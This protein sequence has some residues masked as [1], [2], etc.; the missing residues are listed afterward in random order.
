MTL[1]RQATGSLLA[2][3]FGSAYR[4]GEIASSCSYALNVA[5]PESQGNEAPRDER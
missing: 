2:T 1:K 4:A 3:L 5:A